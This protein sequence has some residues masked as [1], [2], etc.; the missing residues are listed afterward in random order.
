MPRVGS[1]TQLWQNRL[2]DALC[3]IFVFPAIIFLGASGAGRPGVAQRLC[4]FLGDISYPIYITHYPLIY[5]YTAW[6]AT[7]KVPL[8]DG[9]PV[10]VLV[11]LAAVAIAYACLKFYDE[12]V[13]TW[14]K[15]KVL[16]D[17]GE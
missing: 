5:T 3:I 1:P 7:H 10:A 9:W 2:S 12:P 4:R 16:V 6:I 17:G 15:K 8:R 14:L 11:F 13:R